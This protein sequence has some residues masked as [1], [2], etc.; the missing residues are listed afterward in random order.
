MATIKKSTVK[1]AAKKAAKA[2]KKA[3]KLEKKAIKKVAKQEKAAKA[4]AVSEG[5]KVLLAALPA[6]YERGIDRP[7]AEILQEGRQLEAALSAHG[8]ALYKKSLL[9]EAVAG[10]LSARRKLLDAAEGEWLARRLTLS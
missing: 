7:V 5:D 10:S 3:A 2:T 6:E 1:K 8:A 9:E 4:A